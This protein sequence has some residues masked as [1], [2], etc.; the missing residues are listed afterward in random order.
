[1][2]AEF[3]AQAIAGLTGGRLVAVGTR[4]AA[5]GR[6]FAA[7]HGARFAGSQPEDLAASADVD[8]ICVT[9]SAGFHLEPAMAAI[10]AG[11]HVVV[12]KP[13]EISLERV[14]RMLAAAATAGVLVVPVFQGR[15]GAG[16]IALK[17]AVAAGRFGRIVLASA[18]IKWH[19]AAE[20]YRGTRGTL[21]ADGGGALMAQ[22]IHSVDLLQ[23]CVGLP[24]EVFG[25]VIRRVH[26]DIEVEDTAAATLVFPGGAL[27]SIEATT[28]AW[29]GWRRRIEIV[30]ESGSAVLEDDELVRWEFRTPQADDAK[31]VA[32]TRAPALGSGASAPNA[33]SPVGHQRQ[34]QDLISSL[35]SGRPL[36]L[37]GL[38]GRDA[39]ALV[40]AIYESARFGQP[41]RL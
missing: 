18:A 40:C 13:L 36:A 22:G 4:D 39:V 14:D 2:V 20:Y 33:I 23:W 28:A 41:V 5:K 12:E 27:G 26:A 30:G 17:A 7:K 10:R 21:A 6:A 11:K 9:T 19:R 31:L 38:Q 29:P 32:A 15:F 8:I 35:S 34:L 25:R 24:V 37:T 3:H 1:M 16:A